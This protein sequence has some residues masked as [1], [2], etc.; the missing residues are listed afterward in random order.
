MDT[1]NGLC[2]CYYRQRPH[3]RRCLSVGR[4]WESS[5]HC[6]NQAV[7]S[8]RAYGWCNIGDLAPRNRFSLT[9]FFEAE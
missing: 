7:S 8:A 3:A 9:K 6:E 2:G 1:Q 5:V 4:D